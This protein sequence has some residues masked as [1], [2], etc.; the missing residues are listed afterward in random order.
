MPPVIPQA[1]MLS[2]STAL[3]SGI[4]ATGSSFSA[5][6][7]GIRW[8]LEESGDVIVIRQEE[9]AV[10]DPRQDD[11]FAR[12]RGYFSTI[13]ALAAIGPKR[14]TASGQIFSMGEFLIHPKGFHYLGQGM[15]ATCYRFPEEV[16]VLSGGLVMVH[17]N[18]CE[19]VGG[20]D[21]HLGGL[22]MI[23]LCLK[24]RREGGRCLAVPDVVVTTEV[25]ADAVATDQADA[26]RS[27][28][29][30][31]WNIADLD[32][33]RTRYQGTGV[34]WNAR[35][36]GRAM[37]FEKYDERP[38][39]H[40]T[41][42]LNVEPYRQ[43]ADHLTEIVARLTP[44]GLCVDLGCGDGLYAHLLALRGVEVVGVDLEESAI[45]Q[46]RE[47]TEAC[48]TYPGKRPRF[49]LGCGSTLPIEEGSAQTV[50][51]LD[52]IEHLPNPIRVLKE[53]A[54]TLKSGGHLFLTTP[55]AQYGSSSDAT[56]HITE[57]TPDELR[58]FVNA[59]PGLKVV[60]QGRIGGVYR[61][62]LMSA[63]KA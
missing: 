7:Q 1:D 20:L 52:V 55:A 56:Y 17:R 41:N 2:M 24:L 18:R 30:F 15:P 27:R 21:R 16:D 4:Q 34:L 57:F 62:I 38:A 37:P 44:G 12:L 33:V 22:A 19:A 45:A 5:D 36:H 26:F 49:E 48:R 35:F 43:R 6:H 29:G 10:A 11:W 50:F 14:V 32:D 59:V 46:A 53:A 25:A 9:K 60:S 47:R 3:K 8:R 42:Y 13:P 40:W 61:D 28:W 23:D 51:M 39:V 63:R 58:R 31:D 54:R